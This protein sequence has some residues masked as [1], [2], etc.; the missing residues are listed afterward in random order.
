MTRSTN[1][2]TARLGLAATLSLATLAHA[3]DKKPDAKPAQPAG[4]TPA[5][6]PAKP[7][8]KPAMA[9]PADKP[10]ENPAKEQI[11]HVTL[12]TSMGDIV[13][14]LNQDKA[15]KTVENFLK[16]VDA[17][18]YD[19]TIFHR[20]IG[21]FMIQGGGFTPDMAQKKTGAGV[22][23][24]WKN[25]LKNVRG[26]VAMARLGNQPNSATAQFFINVNTNPF[27]DEPRDGAGY[28][29]FGKVVAG[30]DIVDKIKAVK[31]GSKNGMG[32]VPIDPVT[33][34]SAYRSKPEEIPGGK[35]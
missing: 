19:G 30:M 15:P 17:K 11:V 29:V 4:L 13:L 12:K 1:L 5:G 20:V 7:A 32:D 28:A 23:N 9:Q 33:I 25:G 22:E 35:K 14:E 26:S 34:T 31:T 8:D 18:H 27:L 2:W 24:E 16:Y 10:T 3:Q 21:N 6:Q